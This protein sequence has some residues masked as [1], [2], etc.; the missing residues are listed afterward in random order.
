MG[1]R[2]HQPSDRIFLAIILVVFIDLFTTGEITWSRWVI[3][4]M[5]FIYFARVFGKKE[6]SGKE[7][8]LLKER[9]AKG[10]LSEEEYLQTKNN[11]KKEFEERSHPAMH[12]L[13]G[14]ILI[15]VGSVYIIRNFIDPF[16]PIPWLPMLLI[17]IGLFAIFRKTA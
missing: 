13:F 5:G 6:E 10:E 3:L 8:V 9:Y 12:Y 15:V 2:S 7:L 14:I 16:F 11:L 4:A 17:I 1:S